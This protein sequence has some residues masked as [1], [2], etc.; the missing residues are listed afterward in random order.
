MKDTKRF[1]GNE[2]ECN[3]E[4]VHEL[5]VIKYRKLPCPS[6]RWT[7]ARFVASELEGES[8]QAWPFQLVHI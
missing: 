1:S 5:L 8:W 6:A 7:Q 3:V 2:W 4:K